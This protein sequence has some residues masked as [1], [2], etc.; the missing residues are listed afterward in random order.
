LTSVNNELYENGVR[1]ATQTD[2]DT[3]QNEIDNIPGGNP[4]ALVTDTP[5]V[6]PETGS[7]IISDGI[8]STGTNASNYLKITDAIYTEYPL[9]CNYPVNIYNSLNIQ[10]PT[11]DQVQ[12]FMDGDN[13]FNI[14]NVQASKTLFFGSSEYDFNNGDVKIKDG[15]Q[16]QF[17]NNFDGDAITL[18]KDDVLNGDFVL[19]NKTGSKDRFE[20]ASE[21]D[22][23]NDVKIGDDT[24]TKKLY[25][26]G[27]EIT[28]GN[29]NALTTT[30]PLII[31]EEG[32]VVLSDGVSSTTTTAS[33]GLRIT[34]DVIRAYSELECSLSATFNNSILIQN[35]SYPVGMYM[36][37]YKNFQI[38][39]SQSSSIT[40]FTGSTEYDF[41]NTVKIG[42]NTTSKKIYLND[43]DI[44]AQVST[45]SGNITT[46]Q[47][48]VSTNTSDIATI[49][50]KLKQ[51]LSNYYV[52][53]SG[54]DTTGDGSVYNPW[55]TI[56][57]AVT[58]LNAV[59]GDISAVI[60]VAPGNYATATI[61]VFKSGISIIG[62][63]AISTVFTGN[64]NF[65]M[66]ANSSTYSIGNLSN[67]SVVGSIFFNNPHNGS[68][69]FTI[70]S[71]ISAPP[72]GKPC[73][74]LSNTGSGTGGDVTVNNSSVFYVNSD[75]TAITINQNA[76]L[77]MVGCQMQ[78]NPNPLMTNTIQSYIN[79]LGAG[80]CNLFACSLY[81]ASNNASVGAL[82]TI[83][84]S[85][86]VSIST[87]INSCILL[88]TNG[89]ATTTGAIINFTNS[90]NIGTVNFYNNF[91]KCF[92][93]Q[94]A[95]N[96]YIILKSGAGTVT[97]AQGNNLGSSTNH[98]IPPTAGAFT[99]VDFS[100]V[101]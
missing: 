80:R 20:G 12:F 65:S 15:K 33:N 69:S 91:C 101:V 42:N 73:L 32:A 66:A 11:T 10:S 49:N 55:A 19:A 94:N 39:N 79:V 5:L 40:N 4:N 58:V 34:G 27:V 29:P 21:Y 70:S 13:N 88:F 36:D 97:L 6:I 86:A 50:G 41:D 9:M 93:T 46:L 75:T 38:N 37:E 89:V 23:D 83:N 68:N 56:S 28:S 78:N 71:I 1:I 25:L 30:T 76:S 64:I 35:N 95:P 62:A 47:G 74:V 8:T 85:S 43:V 44:G 57:K 22:F 45:N 51:N 90:A 77:F 92:L 82:I 98:T 7:V 99:K 54:N 87:T 72:N 26:N 60:N 2:I 48:Q 24:T 31:P 52:S 96:N 14:T 17:Y 63:N 53:T 61:S 81:N 84:N 67:I 16:L 59:V 100:A 18:R 3:L